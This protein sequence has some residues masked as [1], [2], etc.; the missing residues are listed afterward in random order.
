MNLRLRFALCRRTQVPLVVPQFPLTPTQRTQLQKFYTNLSE[1]TEQDGSTTAQTTEL[2]LRHVR[3]CGP[4]DGTD[5]RA[6]SGPSRQWH[7]EATI[8]Q[9][10]SEA[11]HARR[12]FFCPVVGG[13]CSKRGKSKTTTAYATDNIPRA[14]AHSKSEVSLGVRVGLTVE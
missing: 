13:R 4:G 11:H 14:P 6:V 2:Y 5:L 10:R 8:G 7:N 1:E 9:T 12:D 3:T